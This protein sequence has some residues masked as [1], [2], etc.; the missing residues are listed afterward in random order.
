MKESTAIFQN[1]CVKFHSKG[2]ISL[3]RARKLRKEMTDGERILWGHLRRNAHGFHFRRQV[4]I[5][6][7]VLDFYCAKARLAVEVDGPQHLERRLLDDRRDAFFLAKGIVTL[8]VRS[9]EVFD[10]IDGV[11]DE[12]V[13]ICQQR[14][15]WQPPGAR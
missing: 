13:R 14:T 2:E 15:G 9:I 3:S 11:I 8:R 5:D 10:N 1:Q 6:P 7:Y 4:P 12:I